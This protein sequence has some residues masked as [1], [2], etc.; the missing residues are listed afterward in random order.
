MKRA[1]EVGSVDPQS[2]GIPVGLD[3]GYLD[4]GEVDVVESERGPADEPHAAATARG[5]QGIQPR[6]GCR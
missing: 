1:T 4:G 5:T 6:L 2:F 3:H